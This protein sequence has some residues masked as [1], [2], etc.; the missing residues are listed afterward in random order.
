M[1][2]IVSGLHGVLL[3]P[4]LG[5]FRVPIPVRLVDPGNL[6]DQGVVGVGVAQQGAD[7][8]E[9]LADGQGG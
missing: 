9:N 2:S 8:E 5:Q 1:L 6:W 4:L 7:G 3:G